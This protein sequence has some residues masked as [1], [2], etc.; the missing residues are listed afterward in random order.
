VPINGTLYKDKNMSKFVVTFSNGNMITIDA[1]DINATF[2]IASDRC[3]ADLTIVN[4]EEVSDNTTIDIEH[5]ET[6]TLDLDFVTPS[7]LDD[8][9]FNVSGEPITLD[10]SPEDEMAMLHEAYEQMNYHCAVSLATLIRCEMATVINHTLM[11]EEI[12]ETVD[13]QTWYDT[14]LDKICDDLIDVFPHR[15][16]I[17]NL[18]RAEVSKDAP[19]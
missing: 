4:I 13:L 5:S 14:Q 9:E 6:E 19:Q 3:V 16:D 18:I 17:V 12:V 10:L 2:D 8:L 7:N 15:I 1:V 11:M